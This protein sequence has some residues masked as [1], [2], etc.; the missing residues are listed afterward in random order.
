MDLVRNLG[1]PIE[2]EKNCEP[3]QNDYKDDADPNNRAFFMHCSSAAHRIAQPA[4][5]T[6][7]N[8]R[9]K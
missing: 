4:K 6:D 7:R 9:S 1:Y 5:L 2:E 8:Q 3:N